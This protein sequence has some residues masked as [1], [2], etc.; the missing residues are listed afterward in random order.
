MLIEQNVAIPKG[1]R[2]VEQKV[3]SQIEEAAYGGVPKETHV[4]ISS[5]APPLT[6]P[7]TTSRY[8]RMTSALW[9]FDI[10]FRYL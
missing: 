10:S 4:E 6:P 3:W 9:V 2:V 1:D 8:L 5:S 7:P